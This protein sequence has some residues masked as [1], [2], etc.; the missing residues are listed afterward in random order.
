ML[1]EQRLLGRLVEVGDPHH[2][3]CCAARRSSAGPAPSRPVPSVPPPSL[4]RSSTSNGSCTHGRQVERPGVVRDQVHVHLGQPGEDR[5]QDGAVDHRVDHRARLVDHHDQPRRRGPAG[6]VPVVEPVDV[7]PLVLRAPVGEVL[8]DRAV[9]GRGCGRPASAAPTGRSS[10]T[11]VFSTWV[12]STSATSSTNRRISA[13]A[14]ASATPD[15]LRL[16]PQQ[17]LDQRHARGELRGPAPGRPAPRAGASGVTRSPSSRRR[18]R[19]PP[20][21]RRAAGW[22]PRSSPGAQP[23]ARSSQPASG[24]QRASWVGGDVAGAGGE[25]VEQQLR[26][27]RG[28]PHLGRTGPG[29]R[30]S[31]GAG[32]P[33]A[34]RPSNSAASSGSA[35]R[36][37]DRRPPGRAARRGRPMSSTTARLADS[38]AACSSGSNSRAS[39]RQ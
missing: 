5:R 35:A 20:E 14:L 23:S 27:Q 1:V 30:A 15:R 8:P 3:R 16:V 13:L 37:V 6:G 10:P 12:R 19:L 38:S 39:S 9:A 21:P 4:V 24:C 28:A 26:H 11:L 7:E 22:P 29:R 25:H 31:L 36:G 18:A 2:R 33:A 32:R 34:I 17:L